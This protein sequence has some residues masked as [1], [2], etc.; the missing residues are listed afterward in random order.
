MSTLICT[1]PKVFPASD[2]IIESISGAGSVHHLSVP[3]Q[4]EVGY[5]SPATDSAGCQLIPHQPHGMLGGQIDDV[6]SDEGNAVAY[7]VVP[8][9]VGSLPEPA[10]ALVDVPVRACDEALGARSILGSY[11]KLG[12]K[13]HICV[14]DM[15][16]TPKT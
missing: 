5:Q 2:L 15:C 3:L 4:G 16:G 14:F 13:F 9:G 1:Y 7:G 12:A 6:V 11:C 10:S 8:K